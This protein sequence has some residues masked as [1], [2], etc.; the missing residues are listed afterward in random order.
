MYSGE[1]FLIAG[2]DHFHERLALEELDVSRPANERVEV[3][4]KERLSESERGTCH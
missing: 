3:S 2:N 1:E 4:I